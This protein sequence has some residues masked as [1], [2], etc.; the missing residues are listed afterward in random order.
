M[1]DRISRG[2]IDSNYR[3]NVE[4][5]HGNFTIDLPLEVLVEAGSHL[6]VEGLVVSHVW[7]TLDVRNSYIFLREVAEGGTSYHRVVIM[8]DGNY[9]ISTL[10]VELQKQLRL[11]SYIADGLW[12]V[13]SSDDGVLTISQSSPTFQ[14]A[15]IYSASDV[16]GKTS[17]DIN[18]QFVERVPRHLHI[19]AA[20]MVRCKCNRASAGCGDASTLI[21]IPV[22]RMEFSQSAK[23]RQ[24]GHVNLARHRVLHLC[25]SDHRK[26]VYHRMV[27]PMSWRPLS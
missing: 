10:A 11:N 26:P 4:D 13:T 15:R 3:T 9:N 5:S 19:L 1:S 20:S 6:R 12:S 23:G 14:S 16:A 17:V 24:T 21:G 7:P 25:S 27:A 8:E 22:R 18:W 2:F